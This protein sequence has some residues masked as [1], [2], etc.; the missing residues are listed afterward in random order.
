MLAR[1][2]KN[3]FLAV[4]LISSS[5]VLP[6]PG[7]MPGNKLYPIKQ[8]FDKVMEYWVFG[9]FAR[10]KYE[11]A[12]ADKKLVEAKTLFEYQQYLLAMKAL[13]DSNVHFQ[14]AS[15]F[16]EQAEREG[17]NITQKED[18]YKLAGKKH[19]EVLKNLEQILPETFIWQP[20][21]K[22]AEELNLKSALE[23]AIRLRE[24]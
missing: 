3:F 6:Y 7:L 14:K 17:K 18:I 2:F 13:S 22:P 8:V 5:Y 16:L 11:L 15:K 4:I 20:E 10:Y 21:K 12:L 1:K 19:Q 23:E 24:I 9:S